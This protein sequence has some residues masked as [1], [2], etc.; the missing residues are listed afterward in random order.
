M[1]DRLTR[2]VPF[3]I[4]VALLFSQYTVAS[5]S[6]QPATPHGCAVNSSRVTQDKSRAEAVRVWEQAIAAKGGRGRLYAIQNMLISQNGDYKK[7]KFSLPVK[8]AIDP[9]KRN[10]VRS[11]SLYVFP[12]K[13]WDSEDYRPDVFGILMH[14]YNYET[15]MKYVITLG[16]PHHPLE[17]I[18]PKETRESRTYGLVSY[19]LETTWLKPTPLKI[20]TGKIGLRK[21]DIV[22]TTLNGERVDFAFD[23]TTHLPA[24]VSYYSTFKDK[25]YVTTNTLSDYTEVKGI[26][27][28]QTV[29]VD[30][31]KYAEAVQFD[32][33]CNPEI[34]VKLPPLEA[35]LEAWRAKLKR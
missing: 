31:T 26:Q 9:S 20:S 30:G 28:P 17:P 34:F 6:V 2:F 29:A 12:N 8:Y 25:T 32:V 19:L 23:R 11:V 10:H 18:G 3:A 7:Q 27:V 4:I 35:G 16:E 15:G 5:L 22:Q 14:M 24:Q 13:F 21:V 1:I 33:E